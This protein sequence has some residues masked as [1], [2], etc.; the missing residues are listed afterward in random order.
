MH[1]AGCR[2][3]LRIDMSGSLKD[4]RSVIKSLLE[5]IRSRFNVSAAE[6][7]RLESWH[8]GEIGLAAVSNDPAHARNVIEAVVRYVES[9]GR[10]EIISVERDSW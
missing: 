7:G 3:V 8:E 2:V 4:K 10:A 5:R 1:V 6:V 9:D